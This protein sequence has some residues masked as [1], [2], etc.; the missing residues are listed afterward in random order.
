MADIE[1]ARKAAYAKLRL[2]A[3]EKGGGVIVEGFRVSEHPIA[4]GGFGGSLD[5]NSKASKVKPVEVID[6][7]IHIQATGKVA[8]VL[9]GDATVEVATLSRSPLRGES[10]L[11]IIRATADGERRP[12]TVD[13]DEITGKHALLDTVR[14]NVQDLLKASRKPFPSEPA[15]DLR[16]TGIKSVF[17]ST[18]GH[19]GVRELTLAR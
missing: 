5:H 18:N 10:K 8:K 11:T 16:N 3:P 17:T 13:L 19:V 15:V 14:G 7:G 6:L 2:T 1:K 9:T 12:E 4:V